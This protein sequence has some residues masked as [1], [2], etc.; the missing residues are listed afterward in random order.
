MQLP[1]KSNGKEE[2]KDAP[3]QLCIWQMTDFKGTDLT[4]NRQETW[5]IQEAFPRRFEMKPW[6]ILIIVPRWCRIAPR[7]RL[8]QH[9]QIMGEM[10]TKG[11]SGIRMMRLLFLSKAAC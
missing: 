4:A 7:R 10:S 11:A 6:K 3:H 9:Q 2:V 5:E 8:V 1:N